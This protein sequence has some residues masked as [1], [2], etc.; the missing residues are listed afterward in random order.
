[1]TR[2]LTEAEQIIVDDEPGNVC[3]CDHHF[4][5]HMS[6]GEDI[7]CTACEC[8]DYDGPTE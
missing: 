1:M 3:G 4:V 5:L 6:D 2:P 8:D 7:P